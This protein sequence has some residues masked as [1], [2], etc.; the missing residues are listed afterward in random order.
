MDVALAHEAKTTGQIK[1]YETFLLALINDVLDLSKIE[2]GKM[3]L[4][5]ETFDVN[6]LLQD[7]VTTVQPLAE[8]N[9]NILDIYIDKHVG[10]MRAD[11]TKVRQ[12]LLNLPFTQADVTTAAKYGG[13]GLGLTISQ[14]FCRMMGGDIVV[15][16]VPGEGSTFSIRLPAA[17]T[18]EQNVAL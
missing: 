18:A 3:A 2:A 15:E 8:K 11:S 14:R 9:H 6:D 12:S 5:L 1:S 13:T 16:S 10:S 17:V 4:D 7:T